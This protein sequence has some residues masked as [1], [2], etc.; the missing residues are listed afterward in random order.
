[1]LRK[2]L[3]FLLLFAFATPGAV[4]MTAAPAPEGNCSVVDAAKLPPAVGGGDAICRAVDRAIAARA[5]GLQYKVEVR[6]IS[7]SRLSVGLTANGRALPDRDFS[8]NDRD[9]SLKIVERFAASIA[10]ALADAKAG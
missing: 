2:S 9:L 6:V 10:A 1:M 7:K 3:G 8:V 5:P 4:A